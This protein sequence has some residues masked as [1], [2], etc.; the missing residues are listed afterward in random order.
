MAVD[1]KVLVRK[2]DMNLLPWICVC[3]LINYLDRTNI[4]NG[5]TLN[6]D[7]PGA[8]MGESLGLDG[9]KYNF[10]VS[11]FFVPYVLM[12][13]PSNIMLKYFSPSIWLGRIMITWGIVTMCTA[14][15]STYEGLVACRV[16]LGLAEAGF[17]PS[18]LFY[19]CFW[20]KPSERASRMAL[21]AASVSV[22]GAFGGLISTGISYMHD[23]GGLKGWQWLYIIEGAPAIIVGILVL[24]FMPNYPET[25]KFLTEEEREFAVSRL[26]DGT[27]KSTDKHFDVQVALETV[28]DPW[29]W[30]F[31]IQYFLM[32]N[33]LNAFGY[34]NSV[35]I[36]ALGFK[37]PT[38]QALTIPPNVFGF[39]II[40]ANSFH[41]DKTK[42]RSRHILGGLALTSLGYLLLATVS[43]N[44]PVRYIGVLLI[45]CTN[46][47]VIP[48][49]AHRTR[50]VSGSTAT[51]L[52]TGGMI[53]IANI[54]GITAPFLFP[55]TASPT[56]SWGN[57]TI[58]AFLIVSMGM[59]GLIW[60]KFGSGSEY[61]HV[62]AKE[63]L[64]TTAV[65]AADEEYA[66][67]KT[68]KKESAPAS[69]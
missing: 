25:A 28:K 59:T 2:L 14:A 18:A 69:A 23:V 15:V 38:A 31:S 21:F 17:F 30:V 42:E 11:I 4:G 40:V 54:G 10:A 56:Y 47:A 16:F 53:A 32:T 1:E 39:I 65:V 41:S 22:A 48:F 51:A 43:N 5:Y 61:E 52:A 66:P 34:F 49:I 64:D 67:E 24:F 20:Y 46:S 3:Y 12:E 37:G 45:A 6:N 44:I 62:E 58:F 29:F 27:P 19:L 8:S 9:T 33:S 36:S 7:K 60:W 13:F 57:W 63:D 35:I 26:G 55:S 50:T 68:T